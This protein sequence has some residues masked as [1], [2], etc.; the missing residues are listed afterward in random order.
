MEIVIDLIIIKFKRLLKQ[1]EKMKKFETFE[2]GADI[3]I[4]GYGKTL[5]EA[6]S[7]GI[8]A[9]ISLIVEKIPESGLKREKSIEIEIDAEFLDEL[10]VTFINKLI[11]YIA[12]ENILFW[13]FEGKIEKKDKEFILKGHVWG[14]EYDLEKF[15]YGVEVKGATFTMSEVKK[16]NDLWIVQCVVDV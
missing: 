11:S 1:G 5:E 9:L 13:D 2:H 8:K 6:F 7:N 14:E 3:G 12:L 16:Q 15:G 4:R 10:F